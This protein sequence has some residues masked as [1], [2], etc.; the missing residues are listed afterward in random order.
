MALLAQ[1]VA[2]RL[3]RRTLLMNGFLDNVNDVVYGWNKNKMGNDS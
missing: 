2:E 1:R 3:N